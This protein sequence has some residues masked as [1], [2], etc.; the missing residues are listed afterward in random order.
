MRKLITIYFFGAPTTIPAQYLEICSLLLSWDAKK[1]FAL[2]FSFFSF[3]FK[4]I[5]RIII[6]I[7]N[8]L[9][10]AFTLRRNLKS[11]LQRQQNCVRRRATEISRAELPALKQ[12]NFVSKRHH[13]LEGHN[14]VN[15]RSHQS[16]N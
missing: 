5:C 4:L 10:S 1:S 8:F 16:H 11:I 13:R 9:L 6:S 12:I 7:C 15:T 2:I 14:G 3:I